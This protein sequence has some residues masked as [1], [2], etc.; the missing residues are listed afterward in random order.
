MGASDCEITSQTVA[1]Q[2]ANRDRTTIGVGEEVTCTFSLGMASW[3]LSGVGSLS[4]GTSVLA[5]VYGESVTYT[6]PDTP[7]TATLTATGSD[8]TS[9]ITFTIIAPTTV[10][11]DR[12]SD[13]FHTQG[14]PDVGMF[15]SIFVGPDSVSFYNI[16]CHELNC[17]P[18]VTGVY[19]CF[20]DSPHDFRPGDFGATTTV[21]AGKGTQMNT[22]DQVY[23][24][25]CA[26]AP[27]NPSGLELYS[28]PWEYK[29]GPGGFHFF[30]TVYHQATCD[31]SGTCTI[32]K[33]GASATTTVDSPTVPMPM[34]TLN[35]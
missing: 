9:T 6:A 10:H 35:P 30:C 20:A 3:S 29:V 31:A 1:T 5:S 14:Y 26:K 33:A 23:S 19:S 34:P 18:T 16:R 24:D 8:C 21:V 11:M 22:Q 17:T 7:G 15:T 13:V 32:T 28:I 27:A 25:Y 2:P 4:S 12:V